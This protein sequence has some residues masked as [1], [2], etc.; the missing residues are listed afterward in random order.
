MVDLEL[1]A[2]GKEFH[3]VPAVRD[4]DLRV[5]RGGIH[6]LVGENGAGKSTLGKILAGV[7]QPT[8]GALFVDG[9][10]VR[11]R[12]PREALAR[13]ITMIEQELALVPARSVLEN[14]MLRRGSA[15]FGLRR[16][17][18]TRAAFLELLE[19]AGFELPADALVADLGL[20]DRQK[21]EVLRAVARRARLIVMDEPTAALDRS[22]A[23]ALH[24]LIRRLRDRGIT[25]VYVSHF[26]DEVLALA[27]T[28]TILRDGR[29]VRTGPV[30]AEDADS[31]VQAM[32]GRPLERA[33]PAGDVPRGGA[34][35]CRVR[36]LSR[37]PAFTGV[38]LEVHAGEILGLA[39]LVGSGRSEIVRAIYGAAPAAA[40]TIELDGSPVSVRHPR[41]GLR[42]GIAMV[43]ESRKDEGLV[44]GRSV[45]SNITLADPRGVSGAA[46]ID[47][48]RE[49]ARTRDL[50]A[51]LDIRPPD[52]SRLVATLS[53]GNQQKV[54]FAKSLCRRPRL[55]IVDEPT[56]GVDIG[57]KLGLYEVLVEAARSGIAVLAISSDLDELL[58]VCH[59]V[60]V[61]RGGRIVGEFPRERFDKE[62][63]LAAALG[64]TGAKEGVLR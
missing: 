39:G 5:E 27:D 41:D 58:G 57:A 45:A 26:L 16:R 56:R 48:A 4:I 47:R 35:V 18:A 15:S 49:R 60:L 23:E 24:G 36:G 22:E 30:A 28:V 40:G 10:R 9:E 17:R 38:D 7:H 20:A 2:I 14:V 19:F 46:V 59:R 34:P 8:R 55:L 61:V 64:A 43:P 29:L 37:P 3:G 32:L 11:L 51:R 50:M 42:A 21:V 13:G 44:L 63:M 25:V 33:F 1:V 31:L 52:P 6:A 12:T 62:A 53:G 54:L